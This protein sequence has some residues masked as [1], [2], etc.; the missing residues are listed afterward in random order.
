MLKIMAIALAAAITRTVSLLIGI[1]I[2]ACK[3][4]FV[5]IESKEFSSG[6]ES[7]DLDGFFYRDAANLLNF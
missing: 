3:L 4:Y 1:F 6:P 5:R 7:T 2:V